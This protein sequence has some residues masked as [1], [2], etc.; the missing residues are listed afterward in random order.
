MD[1]PVDTP[2]TGIRRSAFRP[3]PLLAHRHLQTVV[4]AVCRRPPRPALTRERLELPDGDFVDCFHGPRRAGPLVLLLHGLGGCATSPY[5]LGLLA[6]L[7]AT[8]FQGVAMQYRGAAAQPNRHRRYYHAGAWDDALNVLDRLQRRAGDR[9]AAVVGFSLGGAM[10]LNWRAAGERVAQPALAV[11]VSVPF[12]LAA[13]ARAVDQGFARVYQRHLLR[14][15]R[16][17]YAAKFSGRDDAPWPVARLGE[18]RSLRGFDEHITAPL[19]GFDGAAGYYRRCSPGPALHRVTHPTLVLHARDDPFVPAS[20][21]PT[22]VAPAVR[23]ELSAHGG[24]V[25]FVGRGAAGGLDY[26]LETRIVA[27][28]RGHLDA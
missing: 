25:G 6:T 19:H 8:G 26:W 13:C 15:L 10:A 3:H 20:G 21:I 16:R 22:A 24:H 18:I 23:L 9:P 4:P 12:D 14:G 28:L 2:Q 7:A 27:A 11:A 17:G 1:R 5:I